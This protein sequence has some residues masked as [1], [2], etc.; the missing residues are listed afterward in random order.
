DPAR[1]VDRGAGQGGHCRA[2]SSL[3]GEP[4]GRLPGCRR[5]LGRRGPLHRLSDRHGRL[6]AR[7]RRLRGLL[8]EGSAG[9]RGDPGGRAPEGRRR[10]DRRD[11]GV[12]KALW[13]PK[14]ASLLGGASVAYLAVGTSGGPHVTPLLFA[15]TPVRLWFGIGRGTLK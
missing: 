14:V 5:Q 2:G 1:P 15:A 3:P 4:R 6:R 8:P 10:G 11:R 13:K 9:A 7:E 12:L